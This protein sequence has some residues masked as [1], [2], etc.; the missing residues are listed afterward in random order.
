M[1]KE[2]EEKKE[3]EER[4]GESLEVEARGAQAPLKDNFF[5]QTF[6]KAL[7]QHF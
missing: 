6:F 7:V 1:S 2:Q 5:F 4:R 3:K